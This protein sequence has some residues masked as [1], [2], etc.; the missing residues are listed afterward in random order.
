MAKDNP[1]SVLVGNLRKYN[2]GNLDGKWLN[3][4]MSDEELNREL[5]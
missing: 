5:A 1:I 2:E 4:P 3:L